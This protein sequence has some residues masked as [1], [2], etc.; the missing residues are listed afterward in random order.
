MKYSSGATNPAL[1]LGGRLMSN[2]VGYPSGVWWAG[3]YYFWVSTGREDSISGTDLLQMPL[4]LPCVGTLLGNCLYDSLVYTGPSPIN[5]PYMGL[6]ALLHPNAMRG[7]K[8]RQEKNA[9]DP[10]TDAI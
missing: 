5:T 7:A 2:A 1:D 9:Q 3:G 8:E 4:I 10:H 6:R